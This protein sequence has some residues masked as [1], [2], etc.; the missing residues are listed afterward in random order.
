MNT[1][2]KQLRKLLHLNQEQF[3]GRLGVTNA[4]ISRIEKGEREITN[5]M[6][7]SVC[8]EF[9]VNEE[10]LRTGRGEIFN[11]NK[12]LSLDKF[13]EEHNATELEVEI[14]KM[15]FSLNKYTRKNLMENLKKIFLEDDKN[16]FDCDNI[17]INENDNNFLTMENIPESEESEKCLF[18]MTI[19]ELE[20][21]LK[22]FDKTPT[23]EEIIE[24]ANIL[25]VLL[26]K[27][28]EEE[29]LTLEEN[30]DYLKNA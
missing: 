6:F 10:W 13:L 22:K 9:N 28:Q 16:C 23:V 2:L 14:M 30:T 1:R 15:Y 5:Q 17:V 11:R 7:I 18:D 20:N 21:R 8:R 29:L 4:A 19:K 24:Q 26:K 27:K 12:S 3:G 25:E